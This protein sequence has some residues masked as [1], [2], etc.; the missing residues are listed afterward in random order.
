MI[1]WLLKEL[2]KNPT[3]L[4]R[5]VDLLK[6]SKRQFEELKQQGFLTYVQ[7]DPHHETYPCNLPCS[8]TCP[9][10]VVE[11]EG[12]LFAICPKDTE[13]DPIPLTKDD[14][15][16]YQFSLDVLIKE[17]RK[18]NAFTGDSYA[19]TSRL[20]FIG[21]RVVNSVNTAFIVAFFPNIESAEPH[22]LAAVS[23]NY[24][25]TVVL[26]PSLNLAR[27]P[28]YSKLRTASIFPVTLPPSFGKQSFKIIYLAALRRPLPKGVSTRAP[29]LT[30]RQLA[31]YETYGYLCQDHLYIPGR[32]PRERSNYIF[33][34]GHK[35]QLGD[36]L[37]ALLLRLAAELKKE[38]GGWVSNPQLQA[39]GFISDST[40]YQ[41]YSNLRKALEGSLK[42][43]DGKKFIESS[44]SRKYRIST[45]PD[46]ITYDKERLLNHPYSDI[47]QLARSLP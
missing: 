5:K 42:E 30:D 21:E 10:E 14:I 27:E 15:L 46:F 39:E 41:P 35:L 11:K 9:M 28:I 33:L 7:V 1:A 25:Q 29:A 8:N 31:D 24:Q 6:R 20:Y 47:S 3:S 37:F 13:I 34:N 12:Q 19:L 36:S 45:H 32:F 44:G 22:L 17:T 2:E 26:A 18:A 4:F 40:H 23:G 43:K 38:K 16:K